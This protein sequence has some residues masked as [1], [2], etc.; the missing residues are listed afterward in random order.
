MT[1]APDEGASAAAAADQPVEV[2]SAED[3][4]VQL[5]FGEATPAGCRVYAQS[6]RPSEGESQLSGFVRGPMCAYAHTLPVSY[7]F[8]AV[9]PGGKEGGPLE[10]WV[11]DPCFW[12]PSM[13]FLYHYTLER[14]VGA[15]REKITGSI[16]IRRLGCERANLRLDSKRWVLRAARTDNLQLADLPAWHE[17]A[18]TAVVRNPSTELCQ[19]AT[20]TGVLLVAD[21]STCSD[22]EER[23]RALR[24]WAAVGIV[25]VDG[26]AAALEVRRVARNLLMAQR[27]SPGESIQPA[28]WADLALCEMGRGQ[29]LLEN[30]SGQ[31]VPLVALRPEGEG[32]TAQSARALCDRLQRDLAAAGMNWAGY[33]V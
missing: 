7:S 5:F 21:L 31:Q 33:V 11:A 1:R 16:G 29:A 17:A 25:I 6:E 3:A 19:A 18:M 15:R 4:G 28:D 20:Q 24:N 13:P 23:L 10:A 2:R 22:L 12:T 27:F 9:G 14:Q 30:T 26:P 8:R 32:L